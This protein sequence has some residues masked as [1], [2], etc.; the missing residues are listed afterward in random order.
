MARF[1][2]VP[3]LNADVNIANL[4]ALGRQC[5]RFACTY[6]ISMPLSGY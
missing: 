6:L 4:N 1:R 5:E 2:H 3:S